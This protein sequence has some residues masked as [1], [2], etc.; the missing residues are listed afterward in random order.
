MRVGL[1]GGS[2]DPPHAGHAHVARTALT[3]LGLDQVLWLVSARN[4][5]KTRNEP[6]DLPS[7]MAAAR[8]LARGP[9]MR[10]SDMESRIGA[11]YT[12]D[13][14]GVLKARYPGVRFVW[15]MGADNLAGFQHWRGWETL[16]RTVPICVVSR[17]GAWP[18]A[19]FSPA[20]RRFASA[21]RPASA[22]RRLADQA[23]PAWVY[24]NAPLKAVSSTA[25]R[26]EADAHAPVDKTP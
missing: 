3:R 16:F 26:A 23:P 25:L 21:R 22:A 5:L 15:I 2:F 9:L 24:L 6:A 11:R 18:R 17:P 8:G 14:L 4:P 10:V 12:L 7:R 20:A 13:L 19:A 1:Y